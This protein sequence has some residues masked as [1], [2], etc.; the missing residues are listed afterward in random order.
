MAS[1]QEWSD[2]PELLAALRRVDFRCQFPL[3]YVYWDPASFEVLPY[4]EWDDDSIVVWVS[5][6]H[7]GASPEVWEDL[8]KFVRDFAFKWRVKTPALDAWQRSADML[9]AVRAFQ[10]FRMS[11]F[12]RLQAC[13]RDPGKYRVQDISH[14]GLLRSAVELIKGIPSLEPVLASTVV[15]FHKVPLDLS[16]YPVAFTS[17]SGRWIMLDPRLEKDVPFNML[18]YILVHELM[19]IDRSWC[20]IDYG[21]GA[22]V[23]DVRPF[24]KSPCEMLLGAIEMAR[25]GWRFRSWCDEWRMGW[26]CGE[27]GKWRICERGLEWKRKEDTEPKRL[28]VRVYRRRLEETPLYSEYLHRGEVLSREMA[29]TDALVRAR[30]VQEY[31]AGEVFLYDEYD[32]SY[33]EAIDRLARIHLTFGKRFDT[34]GMTL[35]PDLRVVH[36]DGIAGVRVCLTTSRNRGRTCI[37]KRIGMKND[38]ARVELAGTTSDIEMSCD[39]EAVYKRFLKENRTVLKNIGSTPVTLELDP[40]DFD[41]EKLKEGLYDDI[42]SDD[43]L[44]SL[45]GRMDPEEDDDDEDC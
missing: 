42:G 9:A 40:E 44:D 19:R 21:V 6:I 32:D 10:E 22:E 29:W 38:M 34:R 23:F 8:M 25:R 4:F 3:A 12:Y 5:V 15:A 18:V 39:I 33:L 17:L 37:V 2:A 26:R 36:S 43:I 7:K 35:F 16:R 45:I 1:R 13:V 28:E 14:G 24:R 20:G 31:C 27:N 41:I 30:A 11:P